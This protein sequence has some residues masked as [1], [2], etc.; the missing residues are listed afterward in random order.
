MRRII[1]LLV[2]VFLLWWIDPAWAA[3]YQAGDANGD[4]VVDIGDVVYEINYLFRSGPSPVFYECGDPT[5]DCVI[6]VGDVVYL[7]NYLFKAGTTPQIVECGWSEPVN[8]GSPINSTRGDGSISFS[9]NFKKLVLVSDRTGTHGDEDIWYIVR[10]SVSQAWSQPIN[11]GNNINTDIR[12]PY[13]C[14]SGDGNKIYFLSWNRPGGYGGWDIWVSSWDSSAGIWGV[15]ENLGANINSGG[16]WT[17][18]VTLDDTK[19]YFSSTRYPGGIFVSERSGG[20]WGVP[21]W[22]GPNVNMYFNEEDPS[23]TVDNQT[24]Y[25]VR[26]DLED[27]GEG[28]PHIWVSY[29][30]GTEWGPSYMLP[31][32][33]NYPCAGASDPWITPDGS[34]L[35][36][37][38]GIRPGDMGLGDI[39]MSERIPVEKGKRF[40]NRDQKVIISSGT[41]R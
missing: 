32:G 16:V 10:D 13:P 31:S 12:D 14:I 35:Y 40:I 23:V 3:A 7:I 26:W 36:F 41:D 15:P 19:L 4:S 34:K 25:F 18:F 37:S 27:C 21:V 29:W 11:C 8:L 9:F 39:W 6:N 5:G 28:L 38:A 17:P 24:L 22:L 30:T 20:D 2:I 33:I 1:F